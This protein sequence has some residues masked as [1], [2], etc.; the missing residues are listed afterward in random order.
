MNKEL[1]QQVIKNLFEYKDGNLYWKVQKNSR[2]LIGSKAGSLKNNGY[3]SIT[4]DSKLYRN[5]RLI[6]LYHYGY[7]PKFIDHIDN[8]PLNN[9][10]ENLRETTRSQNLMNQKPRKNKSSKYKGVSWYKRDKI[11]Q[12]QI[13]INKKQI[14]LGRFKLEKDAALAYNKA[15]IELFGEFA[16]LNNLGDD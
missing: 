5:H 16:C 4:I 10:I 6:Y 11:W 13:K 1:T 2:A 7:L 15:A 14:H 9:N 12:A 8:D 3:Y